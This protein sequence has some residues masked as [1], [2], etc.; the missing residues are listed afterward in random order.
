MYK[1]TNMKNNFLKSICV[2][3][4]LLSA[5]YAAAFESNAKWIHHKDRAAHGEVSYLRYELNLDAA[6]T[7]G[8]INVAGDD[9][10]TF[11]I[12]GQKVYE[13]SFKTGKISS[14]LLKAGK[15]ILASRVK[16][17]I[18]E[19]G[20]VVHGELMVNGK[21]IIINSN[22]NWKVMVAPPN[23]N[24]KAW[25]NLNFDDSKWQSAR[26]I[27][28][29]T[30]NHVWA[31]LIT[32]NDFM[33]KEEIAARKHELDTLHND[34]DKHITDVKFK[35]AKENKPEKV[36]FVR[37]N[38]VPF[39]SLDNNKKLLSAPYI[40]TAAIDSLYP[41]NFA[42]LKKYASVGY[43]VITDGCAMYNIWKEDGSVDTSKAEKSLMN[44]LAAFPDAYVMYFIS[45]DPPEWFKE[46]YPDELMQ[47]GSGRQLTGDI[48][49]FLTT[50]MKRPSMASELWKQM[51]GEAL[52]KI[53]SNLEKNECSKR[54][55]AYQ[56]NYGIYAEWHQYGMEN[57]MPDTGISMQK[58]FSKY[59][60]RKYANDKALQ[61]AWKDNNV[62]LATAKIPSKE[63]RL[64][65]TDGKIFQRGMDCRCIDF[66]DCVAVEINK[67]QTFFNKTAKKASGRDPLIGNYS[68]YFF[69]MNYP[70]IG[71][72]TRTPE[73]LKSNAI[74]YQVSPYTYQHRGIGN[75]GLPRSPFESYALNGKT[76]LLEADVRTYPKATDV[77]LFKKEDSIGHVYRE[78]CNALTRGAALWYYDF[79]LWWYDYP[80]Y[81]KLFPKLLKIWNE[82]PD[83]TR[84]SEIAGVCDYDSIAYHTAAINP[85]D[86]TRKI[87]SYSGN[88]MY[89]AGSPFDNIM[90][91]DLNNPKVPKYKIYVFYNLVNV[92]PVKLKMVR[93]LLRSG[94]TC[95]FVCAPY[96]E[97][98]LKNEKNAIFTKN[99]FL[100]RDKLRSIAKSK[101][102]HCYSD[103][104]TACLF[105][106][107][108]LVGIY[109]PKTGPAVINLPKVPKK[110]EQLLPVRKTF[111][112]TAKINFEHQDGTTL[113][114]IEY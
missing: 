14:K 87:I 76:A 80:E 78:F 47:Y 56:L 81:Y 70:A 82:R 83:A 20:L 13:G 9:F 33:S 111:A 23:T 97:K 48:G 96:L 64:K 95:V 69:D 11:Y 79:D 42:K 34:I 37:I 98:V 66:Y 106:S 60:R 62:T 73:M 63:A 25:G 43:Q 102:L 40:N 10:H 105:V 54:I 26:E 65:W 6:P 44:L 30:V 5:L 4:V 68:G 15:N 90:L 21:K 75:S 53:I 59:L 19:A 93:K 114:R 92:T 52:K 2:L 72:Q 31:T 41:Y 46:K 94:A 49:V 71:F 1:V 8:F 67:C 61:K 84:V 85:N 24:D 103:D 39:I 12:N 113:F 88:E 109:R 18:G 7:S 74:E 99:E 51:A 17:D 45:L 91:D 29:V 110:V 22:K 101:K 50:P 32:Q 100:T 55:I 36:K 28:D 107:R 86:F 35:L 108:G 38:N 112:P 77:F 27:R 104:P 3:S 58:A 89:F 57:Q 16:N